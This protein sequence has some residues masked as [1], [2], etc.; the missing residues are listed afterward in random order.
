MLKFD[1]SE[2]PG[3]VELEDDGTEPSRDAVVLLLEPELEPFG[4][5]RKVGPNGPNGMWIIGGGGNA[6]APAPPSLDGPAA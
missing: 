3:R 2:G 5:G 4:R 1:E 6:V